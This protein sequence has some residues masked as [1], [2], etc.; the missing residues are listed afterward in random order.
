MSYC[1][2]CTVARSLL[3]WAVEIIFGDIEFLVF[4]FAVTLCSVE[5]CCSRCVQSIPDISFCLALDSWCLIVS[6]V[7]TL[8]CNVARSLLG[9]GCRTI[10]FVDNGKVSFR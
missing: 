9:W 2:E 7:G 3:G 6:N 5:L 1:I 4:I 10:S 8:G